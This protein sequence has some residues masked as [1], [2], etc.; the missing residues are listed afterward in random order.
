[1]LGG[2]K[3]FSQNLLANPIRDPHINIYVKNVIEVLET[4]FLL[5]KEV[6]SH[7]CW[8]GPFHWFNRKYFYS[9]PYIGKIGLRFLKIFL[10]GLLWDSS[11]LLFEQLKE[12]LIVWFRNIRPEHHFYLVFV[13]DR[14]IL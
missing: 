5:K 1:M 14:G 12:L 6:V 9:F 2:S 7:Q 13:F 10:V 11:M 4:F 8:H 3:S